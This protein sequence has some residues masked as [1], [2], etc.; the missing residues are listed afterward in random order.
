M[1]GVNVGGLFSG[2]SQ[3]I[4]LGTAIRKHRQQERVAD[5]FTRE[6]EDA[7]GARQEEL[8]ALGG[9]PS[10]TALDDPFLYR[11]ADWFKGKK[12][13]KAMLQQTAAAAAATPPATQ[14]APTPGVMTAGM[15]NEEGY[16]MADGGMPRRYA[17][18]GSVM[19]RGPQTMGNPDPRMF[20]SMGGR[21]AYG[22]PSGGG[23]SLG[24]AMQQAMQQRA[25]LS[26]QP[27]ALGAPGMG[28]FGGGGG[29][30]PMQAVNSLQGAV[31]GIPSQLMAQRAALPRQPMGRAMYR[32]GG[33]V[34]T[35]DEKAKRRALENRKR[36]PAEVTRRTETVTNDTTQKPKADAKPKGKGG[37]GIDKLGGVQEGDSGIKKAL[38]RGKGLAKGTGVGYLA[39][40]A[41]GAGYGAIDTPTEEYADQL[42]L[43]KDTQRQL[44]PLQDIGLRAVGV[45]GDVGRAII[46]D[47]IE[48]YLGIGEHRPRQQPTAATPAPTPVPAQPPVQAPSGAGR[49]AISRSTPAAAP[50]AA[51]AQVS[52]PFEGMDF[53]DVSPEEVPD[54]KTKDWA[55]HR[56][57]A[58]RGL[59]ARGMP[60]QQA[61]DTVDQQVTQM[62]QRGFMNLAMQG[63]A[64]DQAGNKKGA[65]AAYRAA[66]QYF[67]NGSDVK[68]G[69]KDGQIFGMGMD[70][71][72][73]KP[74]GQP[75]PLDPRNVAALI[76]NFRK[77]EAW[78]YWA[79][80]RY[81]SQMELKKFE[82]VE[83]P[84]AE[85][86]G[87]ALL[88]NAAA[89]RD[90]AQADII[91]ART[92]GGSGAASAMANQRSAE[93][94]FRQA[95]TDTFMIDDPNMA[96]ALASAATQVWQA[97][98][99][100]MQSVN[101]VVELIGRAA[102]I[103]DPQIRAQV[104]AQMGISDPMQ[105]A[106]LEQ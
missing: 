76:D 100:G 2:L 93:G 84:L 25:A 31:S 63:L 51:A 78:Q 99:G 5:I 24:G 36:N 9:T 41:G 81:D 49:T 59:V 98:G 101:K 87:S 6:M 23:F 15:P 61:F 60:M 32:E 16:Q 33:P 80:D 68:F 19:A 13:Q 65:M 17:L 45:M 103:P 75:M 90:R 102:S 74:V 43:A 14:G 72:T 53:S 104:F 42:G 73:G 26:R 83:K 27:I 92:G 105:G 52:D 12:R 37:V 4:G 10:E 18:G 77:P 54:F 106:T 7:E 38:K 67:P 64:L 58:V 66:F 22:A 30:V 96:S 97:A 39:A 50:P 70:E 82:E 46:P 34:E 95:F 79:K 62:Q 94:V 21:P 55:Q 89:A 20:A 71:E 88:T 47:F 3:G 48:P 8:E 29:K 85:A 44:S 69:V 56:A 11:M 28:G 91:S 86:Q 35:E 57:M 40:Q 1:G